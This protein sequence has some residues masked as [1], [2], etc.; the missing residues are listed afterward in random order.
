M[1]NSRPPPSCLIFQTKADLSGAYCTV[2]VDAYAT[3]ESPDIGDSFAPL[4]LNF[5]VSASS[6]TGTYIS[7]LFAV[8]R[9]LKCAFTFTMYSTLLPLWCST[10]VRLDL[11]MDGHVRLLTAASTQTKGLTGVDNRY[12]INS[13]SPSGGMKEIVRSFSNRDKRTHWWNLT[14][15]ISMAFPLAA[16]CGTRVKQ[17]PSP[18]RKTLTASGALK[19]DF[20]VKTQ[21]QLW[22]A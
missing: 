6:G 18:Q 8:L 4:T 16:A 15:S 19:H 3:C 12:D 11:H 13:N 21:P 22:H 7:T 2:P 5:G 10:C 14:S 17:I 9:L 20:V 1:R